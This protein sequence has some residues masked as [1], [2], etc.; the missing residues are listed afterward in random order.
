MS[1]Q[2]T[3]QPTARAQGAL[4]GLAVGDAL[5]TTLEFTGPLDPFTPQVTRIVGGGPFKLPPGGWTDDTS[6]ALC[7]GQSLVAMG[8]CDPRDQIERYVRWWLRGENSV[9]GRCFDIGNATRGALQRYRDTGDPFA[10]D[11]SPNA[12]GNGSLMRLAPVALAA[13]SE[14]QAIEWAALQSRTTHATRECLDACRLYARLIW[15]ALHGAPKSELLN[16][17]AGDGLELAPAVA[18]VA[19]GSYRQKQ[20]P[21]IKGTGYVVDALEAALWAFHTCETFEAGAVLAVNL[22][23]D[24][25]TTGAI[26]GQLAGA[27]YGLEGIPAEWRQTVLWADQ[28]LALALALLAV[29]RDGA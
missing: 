11:P 7:L 16:P 25:D 10:G 22:G 9:T 8:G 19:C 5:G 15:R 14:A 26:F 12:A 3:P 23:Q 20:P 1:Y 18:A 2:I 13:A 24:A 28:I 27:H 21:A 4:L 29:G 6:M 17:A